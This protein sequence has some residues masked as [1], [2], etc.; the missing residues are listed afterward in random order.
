[1]HVCTS[2]NYPLP[3][4]RLLCVCV[5]ALIALRLLCVCVQALITLRLLCVCVQVLI[6]P[7]P[8]LDYCA[9]VCT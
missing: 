9:Y 3:Y 6:T 2:S 1:M 5:Q 4:L 7:S 8:T